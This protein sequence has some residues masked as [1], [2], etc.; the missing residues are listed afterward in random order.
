MTQWDNEGE[1]WYAG[2]LHHFTTATLRHA[3]D[4]VT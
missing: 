4:T 3:H 2:H 1:I